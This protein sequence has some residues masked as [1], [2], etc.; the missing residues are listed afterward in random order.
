MRLYLR[1]A[2]GHGVVP[3][4]E[5]G[6]SSDGWAGQAAQTL[7]SA[8]SPVSGL[9]PAGPAWSW[10]GNTHVGT[11]RIPSIIWLLCSGVCCGIPLQQQVEVISGQ[12]G[13][14]SLSAQPLH[15]STQS[16]QAQSE[17]MKANA[18]LAYDKVY[19]MWHVMYG[20]YHVLLVMFVILYITSLEISS[21]CKE[22]VW[23]CNAIF[24]TRPAANRPAF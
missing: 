21:W 19:K 18:T 15:L 4:C 20:Q 2:E 13:V 7:S 24:L 5:T 10:I 14:I 16:L 11:N 23:L 22:A 17:P 3:A 1:V 8:P 12:L 9:K 6:G